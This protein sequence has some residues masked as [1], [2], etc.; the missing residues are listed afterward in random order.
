MAII[1]GTAGNDD[2][3]TNPVLRGPVEASTIYGL[4]GD[5]VLISSSRPFDPTP[6]VLHG[7][8]GNDRYVLGAQG[9]FPIYS[10][11]IIWVLFGADVDIHEAASTADTDD[12]L[13]MSLGGY[14]IQTT[15]LFNGTD[16]IINTFGRTVRLFDQ[17][18]VD[19]RGNLLAGV[20]GIT[21]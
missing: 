4:A 2:G 6:D 9:Q 11:P 1:T 7:G 13:D 15:L 3:I 21:K 5:D 12:R 19:A 18:G 8:T 16:V 20:G 10:T 17:Y 14:D